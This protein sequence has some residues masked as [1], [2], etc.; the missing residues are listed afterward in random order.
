[1]ADG[2]GMSSMLHARAG[3]KK[4]NVRKSSL[5]ALESIICL[6][7]DAYN[8]EDIAVIRTRSQDP[9]LSVRKQVC[10]PCHIIVILN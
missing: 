6:V 3:D 7:G 1:M 5:Q 8:K 9:A 4:V 2:K 10:F